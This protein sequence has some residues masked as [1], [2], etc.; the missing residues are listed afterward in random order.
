[1][2]APMPPAAAPAGNDKTTLWG[3]LAIIFDFCCVPLGIVFAVLSLL[4]AKKAGKQPTL[5]YVAFGIAALGVIVNIIL[6][7]TGNS[8]F[9]RK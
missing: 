3:V 9:M 2:T 6:F 4:E 8:P 7:A 5:A 1:M